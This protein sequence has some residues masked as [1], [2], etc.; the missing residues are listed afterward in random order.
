M[1]E[2]KERQVVEDQKG[3]RAALREEGWEEET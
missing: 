2:K 1:P 3:V